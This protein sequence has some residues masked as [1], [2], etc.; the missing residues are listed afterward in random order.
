MPGGTRDVLQDQCPNQIGPGHAHSQR[1]EPSQAVRH[2]DR[3]LW[4]REENSLE[5]FLN[6]LWRPGQ[7]AVVP[8]RG[9]S[10]S[11]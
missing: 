5:V 2:D 9:H 3:W 7:G 8:P 1:H 10:V 11:S 6:G 4:K